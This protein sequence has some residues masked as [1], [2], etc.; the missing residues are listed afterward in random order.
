MSV[1]SLRRREIPL[2]RDIDVSVRLLGWYDMNARRLPWR[3]PPGEAPPDPY[4]TWLSEVMLQQTTVPVV[5]P[6]FERFMSRWP[7]VEALAAAETEELMAAWAGLGYYARARRLQE[8]ARKVCHAGRFPE[9]A[10]GLGAL[11]GIGPYTAAAIASIAFGEAVAVVDGNVE[12]VVS[13]LFAIPD[14]PPALTREA[15]ARLQPLVPSARP[16]DF[17]QA[18][19]DLGAMICRPRSPQCSDCPL[20]D[21]CEARRLGIAERLPARA[22]KPARRL[23]RGT[24][25]WIEVDGSVGLEQRPPHGLLGGM[26][27][28]PGTDWSEDMDFA[29]PFP[30]DWKRAAKPVRHIFTHIDLR[31]DVAA[32]R[33]PDRPA[34]PHELCWT[35]VPAVKGLPTLYR[36]AAIRAKTLL[37]D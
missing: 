17:A 20:A 8:C 3:A 18:M 37:E 19:M 12:R 27:G 35:E 25:W 26:P 30:G 36:K 21:I 7:T 14:P 31:L 28:L 9:T 22:E 33:L 24:A 11:P 13:R 34:F 23:A 5:I 10:S 4:R 6:Y 15:R 32:I 29:L 16:G 2:E 1:E